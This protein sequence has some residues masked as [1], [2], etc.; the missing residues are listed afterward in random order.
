MRRIAEE[1]R[2][3]SGLQEILLLLESWMHNVDPCASRTMCIYYGPVA[4]GSSRRSWMIKESPKVMFKLE[5]K[6]IERRKY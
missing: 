6:G 4:L 1:Q 5:L 2:R 3:G